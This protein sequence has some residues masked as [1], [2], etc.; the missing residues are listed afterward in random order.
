MMRM[1]PSERKRRV[2]LAKLA[3]FFAATFI[4]SLGICGY[5][6][7]GAQQFGGNAG[8]LSLIGMIVSAAALLVIGV[9]ALIRTYK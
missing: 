4:I 8:F 7:H 3:A 9:T 6:L 2:S 5:S 1:S